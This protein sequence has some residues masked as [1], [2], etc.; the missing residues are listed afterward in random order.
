M[1]ARSE[2]LLHSKTPSSQSLRI[3]E[4]PSR[5]RGHVTPTSAPPGVYLRKEERRCGSTPPPPPGV[6]ALAALGSRALPPARRAEPGSHPPTWRPRLRRLPPTPGSR[7]QRLL[8]LSTS[9]R[10][11]CAPTNQKTRPP[12]SFRRSNRLRP[13]A[14]AAQTSL[15]VRE[16]CFFFNAPDGDLSIDD[17][18]DAV[19]RTAGDDSVHVLQHMGGSRFLICTRNA[20]QATKLMVSEGFV[21]NNQKVTV[22]AVGASAYLLDDPLTGA[23]AE[24][25][26]VKSV[27]FATATNRQTKLNGVRVVRIEMSEPV[28]NLL[29]VA[30]HR[31][32]LEYRGMRRV[33]AR[34]S[35][36]GHMASACSTP[37]CKR[38]GA[39][40]H[41][42]EGCEAECRRCGGKHGTRDCFRRRCYVAAARGLL[43]EQ[44]TVDGHDRPHASVLSDGRIATSNL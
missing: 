37:Y 34:C 31:I 36:V 4:S 27:A 38:C 3:R 13:P 42:T 24:Y 44:G 7:T 1:K 40:G 20:A 17:L 26:K 30:G 39:F 2:V 25:G 10:R 12:V 5:T 21:V 8:I 11:R 33:C 41:G 32:M 35:E 19:E 18:I 9:A 43:T 14:M 6:R 22:E 15:P 29:T 23:L 16:N 28:P